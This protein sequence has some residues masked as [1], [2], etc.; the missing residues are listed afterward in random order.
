MSESLFLIDSDIEDEFESISD[1]ET[2]SKASEPPSKRAR[3]EEAPFDDL[4]QSDVSE[5]ED[6]LPREEFQITIENGD[7][8]KRK[9]L[10]TRIRAKKTRSSIHNLGIVAYM[11]HLRLRNRWISDRL[12]QKRLKSL[13]PE[14]L[15]NRTKSLFRLVKQG[16][17]TPAL[18]ELLVYILK[19]VI[20]W[21]RKNYRLDSNG[22]RVLGFSGGN[23]DGY[24]P[25][26]APKIDSPRALSAICKRFKHNRDTGAQLCTGLLRA[27]GFEARVAFSV[28]LLPFLKGLEQPPLQPNHLKNGDI[29]LLY[30]YF[31]TEVVN[32]MDESDIFII[33]ALCSHQENKQLQRLKRYTSK[34]IT[35]ANV[36]NYYTDAF[37]PAQDQLNVMP[38]MQYVVSIDD[39]GVVLDASPRYMA[40]ISYR[41]F[42]KLDLRTD[43]GRSTLLFQSIVRILNNKAIYRPVDNRELDTLR[44]VA[45]A[46][47]D[48]PTTFSA[49]KRNPNLV[50][51]R[52]LRYNEAID[53]ANTDAIGSVSLSDKNTGEQNKVSLFFK[54]S[55]LLG[56]SQQQWKF[57]GRSV[58]PEEV[59]NP[60]KTTTALQPRSFQRKRQLE[61]NLLGLTQ[62]PETALYSFN[63]T[64]SYIKMAVS[65]DENGR[66]RL[67]RNEYGNIE[68][69]KPNMVP[70]ECAWIQL[71]SIEVILMNYRRGIFADFNVK[72]E[73]DYVPVVVGFSFL[74]KTGRAIP[75][76]KGV[77]V[78]KQQ[79]IAAKKVWLYGKLMMDRKTAELEKLR[80]L[81]GWDLMLRR[82]RVRRKLLE[83]YGGVEKS[84]EQEERKK[85]K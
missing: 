18:D 42:H 22:L 47:Y 27:M 80:A 24:F 6:V 2:T 56:R 85:R 36:R 60:I 75:I 59:G 55:I 26:N 15:L 72:E 32:P 54:H 49:M 11:L 7:T 73:I 1:N 62:R 64:C 9:K 13:V 51:P 70:S 76:K 68:V 23:K 25:N 40:N 33:D 17:K 74:S 77:V 69:F 81:K 78:L 61:S 3:I 63:Q 38:P 5:W 8:E 21:F 37:N 53:Y 58:K 16:L 12:V 83:R 66:K 29:D 52:T 57:L 46:N 39:R 28:P 34:T 43:S 71:S 30:P 35:K 84:D 10:N 20:K 79:E 44:S 19:Y 31:W 65:E 48:I 41:Y 67:P 50:T 4:S 82:L 45:R 14:T